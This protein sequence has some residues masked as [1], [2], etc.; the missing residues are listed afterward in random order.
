MNTIHSREKHQLDPNSLLFQIGRLLFPELINRGRR[1]RR[2][3]VLLAAT[4]GV[5]LV[6]II[7]GIIW[8]DYGANMSFTKQAMPI[9]PLK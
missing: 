9:R 2:R 8:K 4:L 6:I 5:G 1:M 3:M 7:I